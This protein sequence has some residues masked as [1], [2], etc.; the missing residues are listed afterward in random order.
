MEYI[1][2]AS[3]AVRAILERDELSC[4]M[5]TNLIVS[6]LN[7]EKFALSAAFDR[8]GAF[9]GLGETEAFCARR[10]AATKC[11]AASTRSR[12]VMLS[13]RFDATSFSSA[14]APRGGREMLAASR[15][16]TSFSSAYAEDP[17]LSAA[18]ERIML[19]SRKQSLDA[20][21]SSVFP[22]GGGGAGAGEQRSPTPSSRRY[23]ESPSLS[24]A[25]GRSPSPTGRPLA[26]QIR[27][28]SASERFVMSQRPSDASIS[29]AADARAR[30]PSAN[31][32]SAVEHRV[33]RRP[34]ETTHRPPETTPTQDYPPSSRRLSANSFSGA[35]DNRARRPSDASFTVDQRSHRPSC[36]SFSGALLDS[37]SRLPSDASLTAAAL[38]SPPAPRPA[39]PRRS[40]SKLF[41]AQER[42]AFTAIASERD[43]SRP[44]VRRK[45]AE[46]VA[47]ANSALVRL[48]A[49]IADATEDTV[50]PRAHHDDRT[51]AS[52]K[53]AS[54]QVATRPSSDS[55]RS[56]RA[57][58]PVP[59]STRQLVERPAPPP[60][61]ENVIRAALDRLEAAIAEADKPFSNLQEG[62]KCE[63]PSLLSQ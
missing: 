1:E 49:A 55:F 4:K 3:W 20:F 30:R 24:S 23:S 37:R 42:S 18:A 10:D 57:R 58:S 14:S 34:P 7:W 62:D 52:S 21:P 32:F 6:R 35:L 9:K 51:E 63:L 45:S 28:S 13:A 47:K 46:H 56:R 31:S 54:P 36:N 38:E 27:R 53:D 12:E 33:S 17:S 25:Y 8:K 48:N 2:L 40:D 11:C 22:G 39:P 15:L 26:S 29:S 59:G 5:L 16:D 41:A 60:T 43:P 50:N 61:V 19:S 44:A